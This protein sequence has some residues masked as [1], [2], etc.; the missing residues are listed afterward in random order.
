MTPTASFAGH[1]AGFQ[2][3]QNTGQIHNYFN[4][5]D[6]SK[7]TNPEL[8]KKRIEE[9]K[10]GLL[11]DSYRWV[12]N[13]EDFQRWRDVPDG[14]LLWIK[15]DPGKG[16]T[17]LIC[18]IIDELSKT[19]EDNI[20]IAYFFCQANNSRINSAT[21]VLRGL[22]YMLG[23]QQPS[24]YTYIPTRF[25]D[26]ENG[27]FELCDVFRD[28]L[29]DSAIRSTYLI[30]DALD[31]CTIDQ[32]RL[33]RFLKEHSSSHPRV[34]WIVSSRN[35]PSIEKY[36]DSTTGIRLQLELNEHNLS[37]A[38][39][40]FVKYKVDELSK[41]N[42]YRMEKR[43]IVKDHLTAN[44]KGTFLWVALVCK[45]LENVPERHLQKKLKEFPPGLDEFYQRMFCIISSLNDDAELCMSLLGIITTV[46]RPITL[47]ELLSYLKSQDEI[48]GD[49]E[50]QDISLQ[51]LHTTLRRDIYNLG[52]PAF[53][54][55]QVKPPDPDPLATVR[56][57]CVY[58]VDHLY[59]YFRSKE[60]EPLEDAT[61]LEDF[62]Y[63][64]TE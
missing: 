22:I 39:D 12:L 49:G 53:P 55:S 26:N 42:K 27:W 36:L 17:M 2:V 56:Y 6:D 47:D 28:I 9:E 54:M 35:W 1:N 34:K 45:Q 30:I 37:A 7:A 50:L 43:K 62:L 32:E 13:H 29:K 16:K 3:G 31:E 4:Q 59:N 10:G 25:L 48:T 44:A 38:V 14:Q 57:A 64:N 40:L 58:W 8:D 63:K 60:N 19:I 5:T 15:G 11:Q 51:A 52:D 21:A 61:L 20:N 18:G 23:K 46:Y 41:R 24:L 33:L